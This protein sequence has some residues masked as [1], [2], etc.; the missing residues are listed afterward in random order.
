MTYNIRW[1][2][3]ASCIGLPTDAFFDHYEENP[4]VPNIVDEM[5]MGCPLQRQCLSVGVARKEWGVWGGVYL[6]DGEIHEE[7]NAH[8]TPQKWNEL[9][10]RL[11]T[12]TK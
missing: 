3:G 8:K 4:E 10:M 9:W 7:Y 6:E 5:C 1:A 2:E 12:L 11:T